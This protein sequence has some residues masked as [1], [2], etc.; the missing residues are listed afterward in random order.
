M[1]ARTKAEALLREFGGA[2]A[3]LSYTLHPGGIEGEAAGKS[4]NLSWAARQAW[5]TLTE[6]EPEAVARTVITV[7]DADSE[8]HSSRG[9][10]N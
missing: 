10:G 9:Y 4:S 3:S 1:G 6:R 7:L 5:F 2:F 8:C